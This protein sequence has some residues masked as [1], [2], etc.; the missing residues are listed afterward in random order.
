MTTAALVKHGI[1]FELGIMEGNCHV[2]DGRN[3]LV[4]QFMAG[5]CSDMLFIDSDLLWQPENTLKILSHDEDLI[6]GAYR[7]KSNSGDYPIGRILGTDANGILEVS[8]APTGFMRIR[9]EVFEKLYPSQ[10]RHGTD[11]PVSVYF[12]RRFNGKTRDGGD[13]TFCRKWIAAGGKVKVDPTMYFSHIG[14]ERW[15]GRFIDFLADPENQNK[16]IDAQ[17]DISAVEPT[18]IPQIIASIRAGDVSIDTFKRL[19]DAYGNTQWA[20]THELLEAAYKMAMKQPEDATI[21]ECGSGLSTVVLAATG[22][23][24]IALEEH[25]EWAQ[26]TQTLLTECGLDA[27]IIVADVEGDWYKAKAEMRG[28][29]AQMCVIDGPCRVDDT[30]KR[31]ELDR[32]WPLS[33]EAHI[34]GVLARNAAVLVDDVTA[35]SGGGEWVSL[36]TERPFVIGKMAS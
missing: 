18:Q 28:L 22:R 26:K 4:A 7:Y 20:A 15:H 11:N 5:N 31:T 32:R 27:E 3:S 24:V 29:G 25:I 34:A 33:K 23:K 30:G 19:S 35:M 36:G 14:E 6:C 8:F 10:S 9:R 16:H 17:I 13:V 1:P 12:E 21:L 2:D